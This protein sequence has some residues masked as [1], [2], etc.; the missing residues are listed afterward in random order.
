[1]LLQ[2]HDDATQEIAVWPPVLWTEFR[3]NTREEILNHYY[4][5][6][7]GCK[8]PTLFGGFALGALGLTA[9]AFA[10]AIGAAVTKV[11][12]GAK[13]AGG[14]AAVTKTTAAKTSFIAKVKK[15]IS[16]EAKAAA[17]REAEKASNTAIQK[18]RRNLDP[19]SEK[20]RIVQNYLDRYAE[21]V[22]YGFQNQ[23]ANMNLQQLEAEVRRQKSIRA[24]AEKKCKKMPCD[25]A[26]CRW[27]GS[28]TARMQYVQALVTAMK[29]AGV[30]TPAEYN[31]KFSLAV[32]EGK[33][34]LAG[35]SFG[36]PLLLILGLTLSK[37]AK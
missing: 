31:Q 25:T 5:Y 18:R 4:A 19:K 32:E 23:V 7:S 36:I 8:T 24:D 6:S 33:T 29:E 15:N 1:M 12:V 22:N 37:I 26:G 2:L 9:A 34:R 17:G 30:T 11:L 16:K 27:M 21:A 13:A 3:P 35:L 10:P 28:I 14:A 20:D